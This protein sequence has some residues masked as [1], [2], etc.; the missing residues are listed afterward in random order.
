MYLAGV[1]VG[2]ERVCTVG[3]LWRGG[4]D[5]PEHPGGATHNHPV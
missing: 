1:K 4:R 2:L 3:G 5:P